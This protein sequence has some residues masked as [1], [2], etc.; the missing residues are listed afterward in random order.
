METAASMLKAAERVV[1]ILKGH[2]VD[3]VVIGAVALAAYHYVRQTRDVD[4]GVNADLATLREV[5]LSLRQAGFA[6]ELREPDGIDPLGGVIDITGSFGALQIISFAGRFPAV[7]EDAFRA[8]SLVV[9]PGSPLKLVPLPQLVA[10][11]LYAGGFKSKTDIIELLQR[12]PD[13]D[14]DEIRTVCKRYRLH[15]L[16][17]VLAEI[18]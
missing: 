3:A 6:A 2:Q 1:E 16:D 8:A 7:I 15:G 9:R 14:L 10:L 11:K 17:E 4:L 5:L 13:A 12:N 18:R